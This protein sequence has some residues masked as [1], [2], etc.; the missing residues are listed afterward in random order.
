MTIME[1]SFDENMRLSKLQQN[2]KTA[3]TPTPNNARKI[4][5]NNIKRESTPNRENITRKDV[6]I[7]MINP[8]K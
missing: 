6:E 5:G 2:A 1:N 4:Q 8:E 3:I 7:K